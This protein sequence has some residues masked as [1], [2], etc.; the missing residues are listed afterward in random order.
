MLTAK[1]RIKELNVSMYSSIIACFEKLEKY[2][3][4]ICPEMVVI[5]IMLFELR[6]KNSQTIFN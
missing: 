1:P 4:N 5:F 2:F 3:I 6:Y